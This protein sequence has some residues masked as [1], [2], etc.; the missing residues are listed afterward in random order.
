M[1]VVGAR[2][3]VESGVSYTFLAKSFVSIA[4]RIGLCVC[5]CVCV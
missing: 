1:G 5:A 2:G 3:G 4:T